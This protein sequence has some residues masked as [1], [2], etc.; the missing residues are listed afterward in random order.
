MSRY[1]DTDTDT[2]CVAFDY[3]LLKPGF[4]CPNVHTCCA[5]DD[6]WVETARAFETGSETVISFPINTRGFL[7]HSQVV[8]SSNRPS[9]LFRHR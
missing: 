2:L 9:A 7:S 1:I 8:L 5:P 3:G 4:N 6:L